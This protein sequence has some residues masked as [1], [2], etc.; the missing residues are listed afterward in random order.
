MLAIKHFQLNWIA[1]LFAQFLHLGCPEA[2]VVPRHLHGHHDH[3]A[4]C[5]SFVNY[6]G[7][8]YQLLLIGNTSHKNNISF[9]ALPKLP[10]TTS[11]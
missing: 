1:H 11:I 7:N 3:V 2:W 4:G 9:W 10:L 5:F 6:H 8:A